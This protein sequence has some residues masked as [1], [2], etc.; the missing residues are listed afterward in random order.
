MSDEGRPGPSFLVRMG[1]LATVLGLLLLVALLAYGLTTKATDESIDQALAEGSSVPAPGFD[2]DL[3]AVGA[4]PPQL[5]ERLQRAWTDDRVEVEELRGAPV[6]LN[7]WA[8]WC[9][10]CREEAPLLQR[11]WERW[12]PKGV[13]FLGLNMQDLSQDASDFLEEFSIDYPTIRD[14]G[15]TAADDYGTTG[16]PETFFI[17]TRGRV[18]AHAIGQLTSRELASGV[19]A[20]RTGRIEGTFT[21]GDFRLPAN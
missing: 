4:L 14:P 13:L 5:E 18:V 1:K 8:S 3:F 7:F 12:G 10:P 21:G 19:R 15:K 2:L 6:V 20:A 16:I 11:G 17:D 9:D